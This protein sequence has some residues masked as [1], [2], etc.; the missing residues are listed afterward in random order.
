MSRRSCAP[1]FEKRSYLAVESQRLLAKDMRIA[2]CTK[3]CSTLETCVGS[4]QVSRAIPTEGRTI[5]EDDLT[6]LLLQLRSLQIQL[7]PDGILGPHEI[8][9]QEVG[10][11]DLQLCSTALQLSW[12]QAHGG[13]TTALIRIQLVQ[14]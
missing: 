7:P 5:R 6:T 11:Q 8:L 2:N 14:W 4:T 1:L 9:V 13:A 12:P 3:N 10:M